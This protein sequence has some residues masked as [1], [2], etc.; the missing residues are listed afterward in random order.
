MT[1]RSRPPTDPEIEQTELAEL[2]ALVGVEWGGPPP[3][4]HVVAHLDPRT[5]VVT[6]VWRGLPEQLAYI[7]AA[8]R[9]FAPSPTR[10]AAGPLTSL[11]RAA[12]P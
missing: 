4:P 9:A 7:R 8:L 5:G 6:F 10:V 12:G 11:H 2:A 3:T 1:R